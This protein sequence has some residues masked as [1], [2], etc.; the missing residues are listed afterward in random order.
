M[1]RGLRSI[2]F[3]L[4]N[5]SHRQAT[6]IEILPTCI[7]SLLE[8]VP[9]SAERVHAMPVE[10]SDLESGTAQYGAEL[11]SIAGRP[12]ILDLIHLGLGPD[13][14]TASLIPGDPVLNV[15]DKDVAM[16]GVYQGHRRMTLTYPILN[17]ARAILWLVTGADKRDALRSTA[18]YLIARSAGAFDRTA[19]LS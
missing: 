18:Q 9:L 13:G 11:Q 12:P 7:E 16:T 3:R 1:S 8:F 15:V 4:T 19:R 6:R 10:S 17:R 14:H 2:S 5:E